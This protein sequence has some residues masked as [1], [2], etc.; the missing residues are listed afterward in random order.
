MNIFKYTNFF[1]S[2]GLFSLLEKRK[3]VKKEIK[4][5]DENIDNVQNTI[6]CFL[7][8]NLIVRSIMSFTDYNISL[9]YTNFTVFAPLFIILLGIFGSKKYVAYKK[10][11]LGY[12]SNKQQ[13]LNYFKDKTNQVNIFNYLNTLII[14]HSEI[15]D[16]SKIKKLKQNIFEE[17][18]KEVIDNIDYVFYCLPSNLKLEIEEHYIKSYEQSLNITETE[19]ETELEFEK[20]L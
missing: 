7:F 3:Q 8:L 6:L 5:T 1:K 10:R 20:H 13:L 9:I 17:N 16:E 2:T 4:D 18:Y 19:T 12:E 11:T 14:E 15:F